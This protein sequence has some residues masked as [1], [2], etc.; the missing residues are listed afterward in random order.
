LGIEVKNLSAGYEDNVIIPD[1]NIRFPKGKISI[2]IGSNGCGKSTLLKAVSRIIKPYSGE[3]RLNGAL[4]KKMASKEIA[5]T[6]AILPQNPVVPA[7]ITVRELVSFGRFPYQS[8]FCS[9]SKEDQEIIDWA[10]QETDTY[11]LRDRDVN[12]LSG[13]QRQ[14]VWIAM[15]LAQKTDIVVLDE[16][17]T[18]LDMA[19]QL[20]ILSLLRRINEKN[21]TTIVIVM[22]ELNLA[23]K[24]ADHLIGMHKGEL[25]FEGKPMDVITKENLK[26]IYRI[27]AEIEPSKNGEYPVCVDYEMVKKS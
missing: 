24:F 11:E 5:K 26:E 13:G 19:H 20:E 14:R 21:H 16:P 6:M 15:V 8:A 12:R 17:T 2:I 4:I 25:V 1:M 9:L 22:H 27:N 18:Y 7:K 23:A 3:V 10:M